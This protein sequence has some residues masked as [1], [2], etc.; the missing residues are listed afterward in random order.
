MVGRA[1]VR[2]RLV[3][4]TAVAATS[5]LAVLSGGVTPAAAQQESPCSGASS[6]ALALPNVVRL[7]LT[8]QE[9]RRDFIAPG[10]GISG[11]GY[12]PL[13]ITGYSEGGPTR[14]MTKWI[15]QAGPE[16]L[17]SV[18][19]TGAQFDAQFA[20]RR[21]LFRPVDISAYNTSAGPRFAVSWQRNAGGPGW[22]V[23]RRKTRAQMQ[24]LVDDNAKLGFTPRRVEAY[25]SNG[26][27]RFA[28]VW[29][30]ASCS[31]RMHNKMSRAQYQQ[32]LD[33]YAAQGLSL[34][35][36]DSYRFDGD[37]FFAGI[38]TRD[39]GPRPEV[40][41]DRHWYTFL[42]RYNAA[43]CAGR[44]IENFYVT[45]IAGRQRYGGIFTRSSAP[46][47]ALGSPFGQRLAQ[48]VDCAPG[49]AGAAVIDVS[50][51]RETHVS[52]T[53]SYGTSSTIK[54]AILYAL[55]RRID[56]SVTDNVTLDT[57]RNVGA[58]YGTNQGATLTASG[59]FTLRQLA[60]TMIQNSNNWATN[61][62]ID[63]LTMARVNAELDRLGF[64]AIRL[65]RYMTGTGAP[66]VSGNSGPPGDYAE[67]IDNTATPLQFARFLRQMHTGTDLLPASRTF[68]WDTLA[69]NSGAHNAATLTPGRVN[70]SIAQLGEKAGSN[71]WNA[72]PNNK[73]QI[74]AHL[75]RSAA[76]RV[77]L[78]DGRA[79]IYAAFVDEGDRPPGQDTA[80]TA[81][82]QTV[83]DCVALE[84][85]RAGIADAPVPLGA[86]PV[87][88]VPACQ[89]E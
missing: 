82:L 71:T 66:S 81:A 28:S 11:Q 18:D 29:V 3:H 48:E 1:R 51:N 46:L 43:R 14:F 89:G 54:S 83:L 17:P 84:A 63:F 72:P 67:G 49:R 70:T 61:R 47:P 13:R 64:G 80:S 36:L 56:E 6:P 5:L 38:W 57:T 77:V 65:R 19:L 4:L 73:P 26:E 62:L 41:S 37:T 42:R 60:T 87:T 10:T 44:E 75:Q 33:S 78:T 50:A 16:I 9:L 52:G 40:R 86:P 23:H 34:L 79:I 45:T 21:A 85:V 31:W 15:R 30:K 39:A 59:T 76:G 69:L 35:H 88:A 7:D 22:L 32:R 12:R 2:L 8:A 55:L 27:L 25:T 68:F 53:A 20:Q 24:T 74:G 58:Q